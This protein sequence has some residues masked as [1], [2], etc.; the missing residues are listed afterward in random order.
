MRHEQTAVFHFQPAPPYHNC[1]HT[2]AL[3]SHRPPSPLR[4]QHSIG[5]LYITSQ[6]FPVSHPFK[7]CLW[8]DYYNNSR[9]PRSD[10][11]N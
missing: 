1:P 2:A 4:H 11:L 8:I 6:T 7:I 9:P 3:L 5:N 10:Q